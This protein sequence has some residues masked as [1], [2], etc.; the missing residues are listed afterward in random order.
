MQSSSFRGM[1][2]RERNSRNSSSF[3]FFCWCVTF[4]PSP[5]SPQNLDHVPARASE[6]GFKFLNDLSVAAHRTIQTL[7]I[8]VDDKNKIV[9]PLARCQCDGP[10]R[11]GFVGFAISDES[12]NLGVG[13]GLHLSVFKVAIEPRLINGHQRAQAHG[14]RRELPK[15]RHQPRM[16]IRR[17]PAAGLQLAAEVFELLRAEAALQKRASV[18]TG[19]G[20]ALEI[21]RVAFEFIRTRAEEMVETHLV[22]RGRGSVGRNVPADIM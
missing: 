7:Q 1:P 3:S 13:N 2:K 22:K 9:Q 17:K 5:A 10:E 4:L 12:P 18:N 8:A 16:R 6:R 14:N 19:R 15:V 20:V 11:F 21:N